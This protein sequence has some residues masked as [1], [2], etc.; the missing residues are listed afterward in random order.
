[1][2]R[3]AALVVVAVALLPGCVRGRLVRG[4]E[5]DRDGLAAVERSIAA[6]RGRGLRAPVPAVALDPPALRAMIAEDL[7]TGYAPGDIERLEAVYRRLGLLP[8]TTELRPT[9]EQLYE[10]EGA[11]FYDPRAKRLVLSTRPFATPLTVRLAGFVTGRDLAGEMVVAHELVHA[12]QDQHWGVPSVPDPITDA[13]G[14]CR[15]A[16]RALL[17]GDATLAGFGQILGGGPD[18]ATIR[19]IDHEIGRLGD[20]LAAR[21]PDV[22][23]ALLAPLVV[24]YQAGT[25]FVGRALAAGGWPA[26]DRLYADPPASS[27]QLLHLERY[28]G[29]RDRPVGVDLDGLADAAG[30]GW[31]P[32]VADTLGELFARV[33]VERALTPAAAAAAADGWAGDRL[34]ALARGEELA[35]VWMTAW[36]TDADADAW[37]AALPAALPDARLARRGRAVAVVLAPAELALGLADAAFAGARFTP[38]APCPAVA[39]QR[40]VESASQAR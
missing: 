4:C 33:V 12:I 19:T 3:R 15:L 9:L 5:V 1:M 26:V 21:H 39:P 34:Q 13:H 14:D 38:D 22:P 35:L 28:Y 32:V 24:Q 29:E 31:T 25:A 23:P 37:A 30:P 20:E 27:E 7:E 8:A 17:E 36:D 10:A 40:V 2:I 11:A 18:A 6:I 16:R